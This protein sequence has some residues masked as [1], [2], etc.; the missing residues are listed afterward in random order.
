MTGGAFQN[1][2][3]FY[4]LTPYIPSPSEERGKA[5]R[6]FEMY[7]SQVT[8]APVPTKIVSLRFILKA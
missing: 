4:C 2:A 8:A 5:V 6:H 7:P 1:I 3:F